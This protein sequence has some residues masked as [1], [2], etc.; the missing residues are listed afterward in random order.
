MFQ[1]VETVAEKFLV[2]LKE[3][4]TEGDDL[5]KAEFAAVLEA[6]GVRMAE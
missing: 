5:D 3:S 1:A 6:L 2:A 4:L